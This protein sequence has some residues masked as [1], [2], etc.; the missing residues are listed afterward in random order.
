MFFRNFKKP[1]FAFEIPI[2]ATSRAHTIMRQNS[3]YD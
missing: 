2:I 1:R 3:C